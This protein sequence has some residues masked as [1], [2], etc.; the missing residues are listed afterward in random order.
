MSDGLQLLSSIIQSGGRNFVRNLRPELFLDAERPAYDF[1][2]RFYST[3]GGL[4]GLDIMRQNGFSLLPSNAPPAYYMQRVVDR[5]IFN[6]V[7]EHVQDFQGALVRSDVENLTRLVA[8]MHS[9]T[10]RFSASNDVF[11][12][13]VA[14]EMAMNEY[15]LARDLGAGGLAGV[16]LGWDGLDTLTGGAMP[17]EVVTWVARPNVGKSYTMAKAALAANDA[18]FKVM[19]VSMEM[20]AVGMARRLIGMRAGVNPDLIKRGTLSFWGEQLIQEAIQLSIARPDFILVSGNL[21]KSVDIVDALIQE[22]APDVVLID[23]Q[24]LMQPAKQMRNAKNFELLSQVGLEVQQLAIAR[25][26]PVHQSVQ[27]NRE[28]GKGSPGDLRNIGGTDVV[29]Q[30]SSIVIAISE[31]ASPDETTTRNY[32]VIKNR[33]GR[34]GAIRTNFLFQPFDFSELPAVELDHSPQDDWM[35]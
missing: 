27:F 9:S 13:P 14:A 19:L 28:Q 24:Y 34:L 7:R 6:G 33:E 29:G 23:A 8:A 4:P 12:L 1:V 25:N 11:T 15:A 30:I 35:L 18:G 3:Y 21:T 31:G 5:A 20:G 32:E 2:R 26:I 16:T 22:H 17:G 10:S